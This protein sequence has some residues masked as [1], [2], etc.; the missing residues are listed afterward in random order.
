MLVTQWDF[1]SFSGVFDYV[2]NKT[3]GFY[4]QN[5]SGFSKKIEETNLLNTAFS[6]KT[7]V[8]C[9]N[10]TW[11]ENDAPHSV[12]YLSNCQFTESFPT[13]ARNVRYEFFYTLTTH[14]KEQKRL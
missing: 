14:I 6:S 12:F 10:E 1:R 11:S 9:L 2:K 3:H 4:M 13:V 8:T 5:F 7:S